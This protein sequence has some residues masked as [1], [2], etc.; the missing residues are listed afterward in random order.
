[1]NKFSFTL[2]TIF[3]F[4]LVL[5][6]PSFSRSFRVSQIPNGSVNGCANCHVNP[7][8]GGTRNAFGKLVEQKF[9]ST[10]GAGGQVQWGPVLASYDAD[11]DGISNGEELSD[12]FGEWTT[13]QP[14]PGN[15]FFVSKPGDA[16]SKALF[17]A[18]LQITGMTPHLNKKFELRLVDKSNS[19]EVFRYK[20]ESLTNA[21]FDIQLQNIQIDHSYW[22]DFYSDHNGNG[23]YDA[24]PT[25]HAWRLDLNNAAGGETIPF[26]HNTT[27]TDIKWKYLLTFNFTGM[28]PHLG[29]LL[30]IRVEDDSTKIEFGRTRIESIAAAD[31]SVQMPVLWSDRNNY[32][33][34]FYADFNKNGLYDAPPTDHAYEMHLDNNASDAVLDFAHNTNF[35]DINWKYLFTLNL[36]GMTPHVSQLMGTRLLNGG[37]DSEVSKLSLFQIPQADFSFNLYGI[38][39]NHDYHI[40]FFA[41]HN[42][43]G[44]YQDPPTDH[45]W[46]INFTSGSNGNVVLNFTHNTNFT[47]IAWPYNTTGV[48]RDDEILPTAFNLKQNYPNPFNPTTKIKFS[49]PVVGANSSA[50]GGSPVQLKIYDIVGNE[51]ATLVNNEMSSGNY[52]VSFDA[53]HLSSGTYFYELRAGNFISTKKMMLVK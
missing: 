10:A 49:I 28:T 13:G 7:E 5:T 24:P 31:F 25:D 53:S 42:R 16:A 40:D 41:D 1:M 50:N 43:D 18:T 12:P 3:I 38:E 11:G 29:Q 39:L 51:V 30:E 34:Q 22:I 8:G 14:S 9:L 46:N 23:K 48:E 21:D 52:E 17:S 6:I 44:M 27:F 45:A 26:A 37:D 2:Y 36:I 32:K 15:S 20:N 47:N 35:T 19:K 33:I 4:T